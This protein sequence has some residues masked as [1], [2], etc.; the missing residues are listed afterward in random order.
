MHE[1]NAYFNIRMNHKN[2]CIEVWIK[3]IT[4]ELIKRIN[5]L[6]RKKKS[7]GLTPQETAE[8]KRLYQT[9][10]ASIRQQVTTQLD[11]YGIKPPGHQE[12]HDPACQC[13]RHEP[14]D[15]HLKH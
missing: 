3:M 5:E 6:A 13:H 12:C 11:A 9:Y 2:F 15:K 1:P 10:L 8:Q 7:E 14:D 4:D